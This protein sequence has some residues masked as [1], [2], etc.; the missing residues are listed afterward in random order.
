MTSHRNGLEG[1]FVD[2]LGSVI[3]WSLRERVAGAV[4]SPQVWERIEER[5]VQREA[6]W[7]RV[8]PELRSFLRIVAIWLSADTH[9]PLATRPVS[10]DEVAVW[11]YDLTWTRAIGQSHVAMGLTS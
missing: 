10:R 5:V 1:R 11:M 8:G 2:E 7:T 9:M 4:P 3:R 6:A